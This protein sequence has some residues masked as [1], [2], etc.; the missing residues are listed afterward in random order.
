MRRFGVRVVLVEL[1]NTSVDGLIQ[2][3][4]GW[5]VGEQL[6]KGLERSVELAP[7]MSSLES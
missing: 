4:V 5:H 1:Q 6:A 7:R 2:R 3:H